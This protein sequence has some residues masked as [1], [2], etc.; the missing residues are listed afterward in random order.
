MENLRNII[1]YGKHEYVA[2]ITT[3]SI[4]AAI[5]MRILYR[6]QRQSRSIGKSSLTS[7]VENIK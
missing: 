2:E 4:M 7:S 3:F 5:W 6:I 1:A